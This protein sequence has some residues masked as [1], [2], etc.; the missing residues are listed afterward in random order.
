MNT[1]II[2]D[3]VAPKT[4]VTKYGFTQSNLTQT[5]LQFLKYSATTDLVYVKTKM[6][7]SEKSTKGDTKRNSKIV[8]SESLKAK[9]NE[10]MCMLVPVIIPNNEGE[11]SYVAIIYNPGTESAKFDNSRATYK[12]LKFADKT[13]HRVLPRTSN[14]KDFGLLNMMFKLEEG[15]TETNSTEQLFEIV[16]LAGYEGYGVFK[17]FDES[18]KVFDKMETLPIQTEQK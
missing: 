1:N 3:I 17:P 15:L 11:Q 18:T 8:I 7:K 5:Q 14:V 2:K 16:S 13:N 12:S 10:N 4:S 9:L 6:S